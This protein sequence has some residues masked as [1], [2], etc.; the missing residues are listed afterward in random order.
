MPISSQSKAALE[1]LK[2][3]QHKVKEADDLD[4]QVNSDLVSFS[5]LA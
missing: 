5:Q 2:N 1:L 4:A 3:V